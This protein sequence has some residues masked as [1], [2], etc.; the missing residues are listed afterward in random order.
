MC[1]GKLY[2]DGHNFTCSH[3]KVNGPMDARMALAYSCNN[4]FYHFG[5]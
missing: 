5:G 2:V 4:F 3:P 1:P